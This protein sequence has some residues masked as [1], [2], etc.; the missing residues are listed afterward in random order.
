MNR[1]KAWFRGLSILGRA[2]FISA[3]LIVSFG[4]IG[5]SAQPGSGTK[6][7]PAII[8]TNASDASKTTKKISPKIETKSVV[9]NEV[10]PYKSSTIN[11]NALAQGVTQTQTKGVNG[12]LTHTYQ[13]TYTDGVET[14][15]SKPV[16]TVTTPAVNEVIAIGTKSVPSGATARC[17]DGSY[18]SSQSRRG[19]CSHHGGVAEWL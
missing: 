14:S 18:S 9:T 12:V 6:T 10:I 4:V 16:D 1:F 5:V 17:S 11:D 8:P 7:V 19:T 2:T 13:V 15:R 3:L